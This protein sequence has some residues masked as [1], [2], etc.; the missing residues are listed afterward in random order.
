MRWLERAVLH[1]QQDAGGE[2]GIV[3]LSKLEKFST[4]KNQT[5][6][7]IGLMKTELPRFIRARLERTGRELIPSAG[8]ETHESA[9]PPSTP[10]PTHSALRCSDDKAGGLGPC[11][12]EIFLNHFSLLHTPYSVLATLSAVDEKGGAQDD[13]GRYRASMDSVLYC[14][15]VRNA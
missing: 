6:I 7:S 11:Y 9:N 5:P 10:R 1:H 13:G 14:T 8:W 4:K 3:G 2:D 12:E 15:Y